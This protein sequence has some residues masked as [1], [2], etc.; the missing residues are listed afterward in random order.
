EDGVAHRVGK[1]RPG[2]AGWE[3]PDALD[4]LFLKSIAPLEEIVEAEHEGVESRAARAARANQLAEAVQE[5]FAPALA[6]LAGQADFLGVAL[7]Q[8]GKRVGRHPHSRIGRVDVDED[9]QQSLTIGRAIRERIDVQQ[10][11]ARRNPQS[12]RRL[13]F[14]PKA[15]AVQ[16][17]APSIARQ[18]YA[19]PGRYL[20]GKRCQ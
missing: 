7:E 16:F 5:A 1:A 4:A 8:D 13:F 10:V 15:D 19:E 2:R 18:R 11:V 12:A 14:G 20:G 17:P 6:V 9:A 3:G